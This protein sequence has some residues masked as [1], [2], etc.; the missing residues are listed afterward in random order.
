[1]FSAKLI[2]FVATEYTET[3]NYLLISLCV[4]VAKFYT[5]NITLE[6]FID[7]MP[8]ANRGTHR[9]VDPWACLPVYQ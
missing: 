9:L 5:V 7:L 6:S 3:L 2:V 4:S 1:M 8:V